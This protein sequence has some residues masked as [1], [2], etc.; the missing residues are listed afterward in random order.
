M[1]QNN[2]IPVNEKSIAETLES[3]FGQEHIDQ[4]ARKTGFLRR[5]R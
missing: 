3:I 1:H 5:K 2:A 4:I